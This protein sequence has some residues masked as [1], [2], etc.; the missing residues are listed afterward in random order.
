MQI[1]FISAKDS[2]K[3][4]TMDAKSHNIEIIM[5]NKTDDIIEKPFE[6]LLQ[7][8]QKNL[9]E[10]IRKSEFVRHSMDLLYYNLR[11]IGLKRGGSYI[12][13]P[14][15]LKNKKPTINPKN[16]YD[17]YFQYALNV[18]LNHQNIEKNLTFY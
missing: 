11:K 6:S 9:G 4:R 16:N 3:T 1:N 15:W 8:C 12:D 10:P 17:N 2:E 13:S 5:G 7:N 18:A 14:E